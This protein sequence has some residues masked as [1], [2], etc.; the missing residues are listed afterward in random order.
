MQC[1][2]CCL[3]SLPC[4]CSAPAVSPEGRWGKDGA[5]R[6]GEEL[7]CGDVLKFKYLGGESRA[8]GAAL[9]DKDQLLLPAPALVLSRVQAGWDPGRETLLRLGRSGGLAGL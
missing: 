7:E 6:C 5:W 8:K 9:K 4:A 3:S 2:P 1:C